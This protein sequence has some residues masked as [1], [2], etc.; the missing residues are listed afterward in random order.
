MVVRRVLSIETV[1][2]AALPPVPLTRNVWE[3][4]CTVWMDATALMVHTNTFIHTRRMHTRTHTLHLPLCPTILG[5]ILQNGTC[6]AV[7]QCPCVYHGTSYTQGHTLEQ[8]CSVW[9]VCVCDLCVCSCVCV[10]ELL[11]CGVFTVCV[12]GECGTAQRTTVQVS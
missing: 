7:S 1:L 9:W 10:C 8:G 11:T 12:W 2:A 5:L 6:I 4:T 3:P